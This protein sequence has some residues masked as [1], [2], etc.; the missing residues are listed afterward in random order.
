M[1]Q[2]SATKYNAR[3]S[4]IEYCVLLKVEPITTQHYLRQHAYDKERQNKN[5]ETI[6]DA[7]HEE[8]RN[9]LGKKKSGRI[10]FHKLYITHILTTLTPFET[11]VTISLHV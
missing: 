2:K 7:I 5:A 9:W 11:H 3:S 4:N 1:K 8:L 6:I 10:Y